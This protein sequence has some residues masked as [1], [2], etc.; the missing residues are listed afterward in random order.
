VE[1]SQEKRTAEVE[2]MST[3][4]LERIA[5]LIA[6]TE[7]PFSEE[8]RTS[9]VLACK[10]I[11]EHK[12]EMMMPGTLKIFESQKEDFDFDFG[13]PMQRRVRLRSKYMGRCRECGSFYKIGEW[14]MWAKGE[15][16]VHVRCER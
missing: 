8:A 1:R 15:G 7:S 16:S 13:N 14:V 3:K 12:I 11:R 2:S 6:L 5:A 9:A 10:L 4:I